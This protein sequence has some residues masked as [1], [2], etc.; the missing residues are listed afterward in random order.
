[1]SILDTTIPSV[2][3]F[4]TFQAPATRITSG[5]FVVGYIAANPVGIYRAELDQVSASQQRSYISFDGFTFNIIDDYGSS[6]TVERMR[7]GVVH[8]ECQARRETG[9]NSDRVALYS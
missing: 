9:R 1:V 4:S 5:D 3:G 7:V 2:G 6:T 8:L